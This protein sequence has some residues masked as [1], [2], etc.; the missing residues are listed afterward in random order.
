[1]QSKSKL[2]MLKVQ[3]PE[4]MMQLHEIIDEQTGQINPEAIE[5]FN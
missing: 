4:I 1:M 5:E 2:N 3:H